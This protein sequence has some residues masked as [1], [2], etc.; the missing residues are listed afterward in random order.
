MLRFTVGPLQKPT[1]FAGALKHFGISAT[2]R[3]KIKNNGIC[4]RNGV[5]ASMKDLVHQGDSLEVILQ[6]K[7]TIEAEDIPLSVAYEDDYLIVVNKPPGMLMH[8]TSSERFG[9]LANAVMYYYKVHG[10]DHDYHP[11]HRLDRNTSGLCLIA[12]ESYVQYLFDK[13]RLFYARTY[14]ALAQGR[15]PAMLATVHTPIGRD[16]DSI[17]KRN[18]REDGKEAH[19]DFTRLAVCDD[20][21]L[22]RITLHT[23]RTHQIR[24]HSAYL[25]HPLI[26]D[27]L[28]G[29]SRRF[30]N[31]QALHAGSVRFIHPVTGHMTHV[32]V[33]LPTDMQTLVAT[34]CWDI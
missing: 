4:L 24:V 14:T 21:S 25:G 20:F 26:G 28:Y 16:P 27:D 19:S 29:G 7:D 34:A 11:V 3:R 31:R 33:P 12:K 17:I 9:T 22:I 6:P 2:S 32:N 23:G 15:F 8:Q 1:S 30:L 10:C 13:N 5:P 18:T